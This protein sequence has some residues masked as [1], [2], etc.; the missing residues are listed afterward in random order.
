M[1]GG[2]I[3]EDAKEEQYIL[4]W[5]KRVDQPRLY[6]VIYYDMFRS[7]VDIEVH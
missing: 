6:L 3:H 2:E 7:V 1:H 4:E 5:P